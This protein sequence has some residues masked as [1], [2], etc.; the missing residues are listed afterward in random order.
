MSGHE[1]GELDV[2]VPHSLDGQRLD[3]SIAMLTGLARAAV[4]R[5]GPATAG[6]R[7]STTSIVTSAAS[8]TAKISGMPVCSS[9]LP[10]V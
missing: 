2:E 9:R 8:R 5:P 4:A 1:A 6:S 7:R 10:Q 3:R